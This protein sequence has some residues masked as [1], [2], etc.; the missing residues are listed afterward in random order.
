MLILSSFLTQSQII[1]IE[2]LRKVT[3]TV[4]WSGHIRLKTN[5]TKNKNRIF[6]IS[7]NIRL[8][9]KKG[10]NLWLFINNIDFK[11]ANSKSLVSRNGQHLRHNY[12][13]GK[14][15]VLETFVQRQVDEISFIKNRFLIGNGL[16]FKLSKL[17]NYKFYFGSLIM[18]EYEH[19]EADV[20]NYYN[21]WRNSSYISF[22][23]YPTENITIV[24]TTYFQPRLDKF[25]DF[26][27]SSQTSIVLKIIKNLAF[28][29]QF[30]YQ[31]DSFPVF[32]VPKEQYKLTN[33]ILY[34]FN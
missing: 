14:R 19:S 31:F 11:E 29:T 23:L 26:R 24:S 1:N 25:N 13:L 9:Y 30:T 16:R 33:G 22:S 17:E 2:S 27:L 20:T 6:D 10:K 12:R 32:S 5:I 15:T 21:H 7:N 34:S 3:D 18:Y 28:T 8:Q 4:G